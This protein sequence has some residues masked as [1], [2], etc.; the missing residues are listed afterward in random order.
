MSG[1]PAGAQTVDATFR[2]DIEQ[3]LEVTGAT[4]VG[5]RAASL[6]TGQMLELL[7]QS[8]PNAPAE[9]FDVARQV[10]DEELTKNFASGDLTSRLVVIYAKHLTPDDVKGLLTFYQSDVGRKLIAVIPAIMQESS[11]AGEQW[12]KELMPGILATL[13]R[14]LRAEGLLK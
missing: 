13:E 4:G 2:S 11:V 6:I 14:R 7:K 8:Q 5:A 12:G 1:R 9:W 10:F 3:L